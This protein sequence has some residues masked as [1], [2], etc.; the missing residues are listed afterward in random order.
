[1]AVWYALITFL[2]QCP[3]S[4]ADLSQSSPRICKPYLTTRSHI[5]PYAQV[6]YDNYASAYVEKA[7]PY[8]QQLDQHVISPASNFAKE[9]YQKYAAPRLDLV[10]TYGQT[11][12]QKAIIPQVES[13]QKKASELYDGSVAPHVQ[14]VSTAAEP[15]L[16][17]ARENA[18]KVHRNHIF[19]AYET[20]KPYVLNAYS[21]T[22]A[23]TL[24]TG[25]PHA[26]R[27]WSTLI[28]FVDG[29]L[30]PKIKGLYGD[31]VKPQ[32]VLISERISKY[33]EGR[34][35]KAAMDEVDSSIEASSSTTIPASSETGFAATLQSVVESVTARG[36]AQPS[37]TPLT[38]EQQIA[39]AREQIASDLHTWQ[40]K[41]AVAA[42][43][44]S[45]DLAE[46]VKDLIERL[47]KS[48]IKGEGEGLAI[49]LSKTTEIE[50]VDVKTKIKKVVSNLS[51]EA[52]TSEIG[53]AEKE[54]LEA[55]RASG[56][57]VRS[58][59]SAVRQ[60]FNKFEAEV[61]QRA[62]AA[63][64]TTL[65]VLDGIRDLGLQEIGMRWAW[66]DGVTYKDWA[67]YHDLKKQFEDWRSEVR[68][69][70]LKHEIL[71]EAKKSAE[72]IVEGSME[73]A[74]SAA[75]ELTRLKEVGKW[76]VA[77]RDS[78]DDFDSRIMPAAAVSAA[79]AAAKNAKVASENIL[80][81]SQGTVESVVSRASEA[82]R[83]A[84]DTASSAVVASSQKPFE[85]VVSK[86]TEAMVDA[87]SE[88]SSTAFGETST[89]MMGDIVGSLS[90]AASVVGESVSSATVP[91]VDSASSAAEP[92]TSAADPISSA[93][94][95]VVSAGDSVSSKASKV[96]AGAM[97]QILVEARQPILDDVIDDSEDS[98]FS[99]KLQSVVSE[100]GDRYAD[101]T[102]AVSEALM[103]TT[104]GTVESAT[105]L[106]S[107]RYS[108]ALA[109]ASSALYGGSAEGV[110]SAAAAKYSE[111]VAA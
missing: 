77:A 82:V 57:A 30:W 107:E 44:G 33:Q 22:K 28:I 23:F 13:V 42:D 96:F 45:A 14:K 1:M 58:R 83:D 19:P 53:N 31:N 18:I 50:L 85:S 29:T 55:V 71:D 84:A 38:G 81:T 94:S 37:K 60:W 16:G 87:A 35:L 61:N 80:G 24:D 111:A 91:L 106:A 46:R 11:Q 59:A 48:D 15:Y 68:D 12:W 64:E 97:A 74:A 89:G 49:A 101:V 88:A 105:S 93:S 100:A 56:L 7:R 65:D 36:E 39:A 110:A 10:K 21:S 70:A 3:S 95:A 6:Y 34:K 4:I 40:E 8:A 32:L 2:F 17:A 108:S 69:V 54:I 52:S 72:V 66:M 86:A 92:V 9:N 90:S 41:F 75:Q 47:M 103:G 63:S 73:V 67:K 102:K 76:K 26:Q 25:L 62:T 27:A 5:Q 43:K 109:A 51:E 104:Q 20:S 99:E 78:S 98:T 79:S